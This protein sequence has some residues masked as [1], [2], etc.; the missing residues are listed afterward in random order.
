MLESTL[1]MFF[2]QICEIFK[3]TYFEEHLPTDTSINERQLETQ[4]LLGKKN[5]SYLV[6]PVSY[7]VSYRWIGMDAQN[8]RTIFLE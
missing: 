4:A 1:L 5:E 6:N 7:P 3:N 8:L 2:C